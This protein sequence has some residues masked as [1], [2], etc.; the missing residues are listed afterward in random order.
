MAWDNNSRCALEAKN[1]LPLP[2]ITDKNAGIEKYDIILLCFPIWWYIAP[3]VVN[4]FLK[5]YNFKGKKLF[6]LELP[7]QVDS[8]IH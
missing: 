6:Y 4:T 2:E 7:H 3:K 1:K 5:S 8:E